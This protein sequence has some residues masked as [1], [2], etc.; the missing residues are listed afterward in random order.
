VERGGDEGTDVRDGRNAAGGGGLGAP[1]AEKAVDGGEEVLLGGRP[2]GGLFGF[3]VVEAV[4][5][6]GGA[7]EEADG[8]EIDG[9]YVT[10]RLLR[11]DFGTVDGAFL[12]RGERG[13]FAFHRVGSPL[14]GADEAHLVCGG[15]ELLTGYVI[16][17]VRVVGLAASREPAIYLFHDLRDAAVG[18]F[19][20]KGDF[21]L[22]VPPDFYAAVDFE[23]AVA[24]ATVAGRGRS[25]G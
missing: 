7:D 18:D 4:Q 23:I 1:A 21:P 13:G 3:G 12:G 24:G 17:D 19:V 20:V 25:R 6:F 11:P 10:C 8:R 14:D 9:R 2:G 5:G 15:G 22:R 16:F